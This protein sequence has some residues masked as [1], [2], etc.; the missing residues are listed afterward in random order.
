MEEHDG[1]VK[2]V[3][4]QHV[5]LVGDLRLFHETADNT[6]GC[7]E[8]GPVGVLYPACVDFCIKNEAHLGHAQQEDLDAPSLRLVVYVLLDGE[9]VLGGNHALIG[10]ELLVGAVVAAKEREHS[11]ELFPHFVNLVGLLHSLVRLYRP[12]G[13][14]AVAIHDFPVSR[15]A[16]DKDVASP[17][18][19]APIPW[20]DHALLHLKPQAE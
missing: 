7:S 5:V 6:A 15:G 12:E 3:H 17:L 13:D 4:E 14:E 8:E 11:V 20:L 2:M 1:V 18:P 19:V 16:S 9:E 10:D